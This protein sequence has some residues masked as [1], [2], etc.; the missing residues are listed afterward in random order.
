MPLTTV[1]TRLKNTTVALGAV[2]S[3][4]LV[5][6]AAAQQTAA[7][8]QL[9]KIGM[10]IVSDSADRMRLASQLRTLGQQ[11]AAAS[12]AVSSGM[13]TDVT[14]TAL[15]QA[16]ADF[17]HYLT[18][19]RDG[20]QR[21]NILQPETRSATL[22][23]IDEI[24]EEWQVMQTAATSILAADDATAQRAVIE[25]QADRMLE[26][27]NL[28]AADITGQYAYPYEVTTADALLIEFA[29]RQQMLSQKLAHG[30][31][32]VWSTGGN[33][34][35]R[36]DL[37]ETMEVFEASLNALRYGMPEVGLAGAPNEAIRDDLDALL[38]RWEGIRSNGERLLDG[39]DVDQTQSAEI[40]QTL[41][42]ELVAFDG[43]LDSYKA[44]A[45]RTH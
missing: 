8:P 13:E 34:D 23:R 6:P 40:Y 30:A 11:V 20:D 10:S 16:M 44:Y 33:G 35:A 1:K 28:L 36:E 21:L 5:A 45:E 32:Q 38:A 37:R 17:D 19:L 29:G 9:T 18:A 24:R 14:R 22:A 4:G 15:E 25:G 3:L 31:C 12:C 26:L 41:E 43:L 39:G 27:T 2:L 7:T 42:V